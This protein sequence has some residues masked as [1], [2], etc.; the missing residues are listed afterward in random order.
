MPKQKKTQPNKKI[1]N[2]KLENHSVEI[3]QD[4]QPKITASEVTLESPLEDKQT[5]ITTPEVTLES[6]LEDKQTEVTTPDVTLESHLEDNQP[7]ITE[8]EVTLEEKND[9]FFQA[10]TTLHG[11]I[12]KDEELGYAIRIGNQLYRLFIFPSKYRG[13]LKQIEKNPDAQLYLRAYPKYQII[14]KKTPE[15][16]FQVVAWGEENQW[17]EPG[18]YLFRG[19]WQFV[20]QVKTPVI[21]VYRNRG[22]K[23][24]MGKFKATH[25]PIL[26]KREDEATPFRFNPKMD[27]ENLPPKWF[28]QAQF[29]FIPSKAC[30]GW[31][32][33][34]EPPTKGIPR[35]KKPIKVDPKAKTEEK[36]EEIKKEKD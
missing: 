28:I 33:D 22:S 29:K 15:I 13:W 7:E 17:S 20:P 14:P 32:E 30:W 5:E 19:I 1:S 36:K 12:V 16:Y 26:M 31:M 25:L 10:I 6:P 8:S 9:F 3:P 18:V 23:D 2:Q 21:S 24:Q 27:K 35:Y 11:K 4:D 34:L